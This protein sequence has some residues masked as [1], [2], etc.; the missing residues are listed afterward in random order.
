MKPIPQKTFNRLIRK[1]VNSEKLHLLLRNPRIRPVLEQEYGPQVRKLFDCE[2]FKCK[3]TLK[4][5]KK[6]SG[7]RRM[8]KPV[9]HFNPADQAGAVSPIDQEE[10]NNGLSTEAE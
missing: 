2:Q 6:N 5:R 1:V 10:Q 7:R 4:K 8:I 9:V 3:D